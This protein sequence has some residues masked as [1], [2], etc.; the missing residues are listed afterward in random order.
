LGVRARFVHAHVT[1]CASFVPA[2]HHHHLLVCL[3]LGWFWVLVS[4]LVLGS[5]FATGSGFAPVGSGFTAAGPKFHCCWTWF[6]CC[7]FC[8]CCFYCCCRFCCCCPSFSQCL[9]DDLYGCGVHSATHASVQHN[10]RPPT[11]PLIHPRVCTST[12]TSVHQLARPHIH[13]PVR[14]ADADVQLNS[15]RGYDPGSPA[16]TYDSLFVP[17]SR[18]RRPH[19][20]AAIPA[21]RRPRRRAQLPAQARRSRHR[22]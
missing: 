20:P 6:R 13:P 10:A 3:L 8:C 15:C 21:P 12:H 11:R 5:G 16:G 4:L 1:C 9:H 22:L 17:P 14:P 7:C 18:A 2:S 19:T